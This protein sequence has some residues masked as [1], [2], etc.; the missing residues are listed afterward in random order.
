MPTPE[1][2][3]A[4]LERTIGTAVP[5][6]KPHWYMTIHATQCLLCGRDAYPEQRMRVAGKRPTDPNLRHVYEEGDYACGEH[7][8]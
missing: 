3:D 7:F 5:V 1:S 2:A 4:I 6:T 8:C